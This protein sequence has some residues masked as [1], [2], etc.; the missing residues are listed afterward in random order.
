[1]VRAWLRSVAILASAFVLALAPA[2]AHAQ[3]S[4]F[5]LVPGDPMTAFRATS[6]RAVTSV[7]DVDGPGFARAFRVDVHQPGE[8]WDVELGARIGRAVSRGEV[9]AV[10]FHA[11]A[12]RGALDAGEAYF[13]VYAQKASPNWDKSLHESLAVGPDWQAFTLPFSWG[14]AYAAGQ[15]SVVFGLGGHSQAI[16]IGGIAAIGFG[17]GVTLDMLPPAQFTY[18]DSGGGILREDSYKTLDFSLFKQFRIGTHRL[19]FRA[20]AFN[21]TNT[22]SF[23]APNTAIDTTAGGRVTSTASAPR[24]MQFALK[25]DF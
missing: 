13:T 17:P 24:Q 10:T 22:P 18:G 4:G 9:A 8:S 2:R 1:M 16:E 14:A 15:A 20:E 21:L 5:P 12:V 6:S 11:R 25:Y 19:V 3:P 23:N 7:V